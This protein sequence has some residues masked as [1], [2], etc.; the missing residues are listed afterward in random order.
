[1]Y[2]FYRAAAVTPV[3]RVGDTNFNAN[4]IIAA[5]RQCAE[6]KCAAVVFPEHAETAS[7]NSHQI[8]QKTK[9]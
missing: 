4:E 2:G 5:F 1:M 9:H 8:C 6:Q 3:M 7:S